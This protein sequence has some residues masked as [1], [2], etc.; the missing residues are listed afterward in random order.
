[1]KTISLILLLLLSFRLSDGAGNVRAGEPSPEGPAT[2]AG[3]I[4]LSQHFVDPAAPEIN[5][6]GREIPAGLERDGSLADSCW[7]SQA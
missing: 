5:G 6:S 7:L 3:V 4:S 2:E 1:M